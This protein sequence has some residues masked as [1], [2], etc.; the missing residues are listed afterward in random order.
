M[1]AL[2]PVLPF[3]IIRNVSWSKCFTSKHFE[4]SKCFTREVTL[5]PSKAVQALPRQSILPHSATSAPNPACT[6]TRCLALT[7][8]VKHG[9]GD[10]RRR[11]LRLYTRV[12]AAPARDEQRRMR[13]R[14][15]RPAPRASAGQLGRHS[16]AGRSDRPPSRAC[17]GAPRGAA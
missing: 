4:V 13:R 11:S 2:K 10:A 8:T 14:A 16:G 6:R 9:I 1:N 7:R 5:L 3:L 15:S 12:D 17:S